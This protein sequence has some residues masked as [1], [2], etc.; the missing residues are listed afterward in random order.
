MR[1]YLRVLAISFGLT[2]A[3][4]SSSS[5]PPASTAQTNDAGTAADSATDAANA[6]DAPTPNDSAA[7]ATVAMARSEAPRDAPNAGAVAAVVDGDSAF[8]FDMFAKARADAAGKNLVMSPLSISLALSMT[9]AGAEGATATE[10]AK[11]LH[12]DASGLDVH[13]GHN[14]LS[15]A[16]EGRAAEAFAYGQNAAKGGGTA[17][18]ADN[19]RLHVVNSVWGDKTYG[20][21]KPFL[22]TLAKSYGTGVALADFIHQFD[23]ERLRINGWV[24]Q[25]TKSKINDLIPSGIVTK[26]T[27]LVLVNAMHLKLPWVSPFQKS[28]TASG[29]FVRADGSKVTA[30]FMRQ[31]ASFKYLD[32]AQ[33]QLVSLP[34]G[35]G[36]LSLIV[37]MPKGGLDAFEAGLTAASWKG[38]LDKRASAEVLLKLPKFDFTTDSILMGKLFAS[39][40]MTQAFDRDQANFLGMCKSPPNNE[41]LYISEVVHKAMMA[42]D[43]QGAEAAAAT[44]VVVGPPSAVPTPVEMTVSKPFVVAIVDEPTKALVFLGH[45]HDPSAK[46]AP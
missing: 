6:S 41:R 34:L 2:L 4:C 27:R 24:S 10:I 11:V 16:L 5:S 25:E 37:A 30:D 32:D 14:A 39:L 31:E 7:P 23:A 13:A 33:A 43:E 42:I 9:Y 28:A 21:E 19:Y 35:A 44:A 8:A 15:Q 12:W 26:D 3:A 20:W 40:G 17:P 29:D 46:G 45:I 1:S 38:L 36:N 18:S 22:D